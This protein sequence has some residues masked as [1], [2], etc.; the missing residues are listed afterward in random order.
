VGHSYLP[1]IERGEQQ[2][3]ICRP[4]SG[5]LGGWMLETGIGESEWI[6]DQ[7]TAQRLTEKHNTE[8][9]A[10]RQRREKAEE[11]AQ[12]AIAK[13]KE[14]AARIYHLI[15]CAEKQA[16][17]AMTFDEIKLSAHNIQARR[18]DLSL[19]HQ[20]DAEVRRPL[21]DLLIEIRDL[22]PNWTMKDLKDRIDAATLAQCKETGT[23][24]STGHGQPL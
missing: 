9:A 16:G 24:D 4:A 14:D 22:M 19:L 8:L 10:E 20:H 5:A 17:N 23:C 21:V 12:A 13:D 7:Y 6:S 3:W 1:K 15:E 2:K 18:T 11:S